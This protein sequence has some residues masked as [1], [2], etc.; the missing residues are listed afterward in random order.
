MTE[1]PQVK[2]SYVSPDMEMGFPGTVTASVVYT[3]TDNNE[4]VMDYTW[5]TDKKTVVNL[6]NH[7]YFN[8]HGINN[9]DIV[10]H[11]L[12]LRASAFT[13]VDSFMI[14]TGEIRPIA[15]LL[16][17]LPQLT[18]LAKD[19]MLNMISCIW[20]KGMIITMYLIIRRKLM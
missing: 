19:L 12:V 18:Q 20:E 9:Y 15:G 17:I 13:P 10:S 2:F 14:P 7:A 16:L 8:L 11:V 6:T 3:W 5:T 1:Y 4:I